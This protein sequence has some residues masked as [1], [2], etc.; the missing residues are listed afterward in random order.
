MHYGNILIYRRATISTVV[1]MMANLKL[2]SL[3]LL[4]A[5]CLSPSMAY[6]CSDDPDSPPDAFE[7]HGCYC[8]TTEVAHTELFDRYRE[9]FEG[10]HESVDVDMTIECAFIQTQAAYYYRILNRTVLTEIPVT[11]NGA[12][13]YSRVRCL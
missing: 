1:I 3:L 5:V 13:I 8:G 11:P 9:A 2:S 4:M 7:E 10:C 6:I 12:Q